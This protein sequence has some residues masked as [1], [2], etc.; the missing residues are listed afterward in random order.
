MEKY[1]IYMNNRSAHY[2]GINV[3]KYA[4]ENYKTGFRGT[5]DPDR[6]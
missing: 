4:Q 5:K 1:T 2:L 6:L 3:T